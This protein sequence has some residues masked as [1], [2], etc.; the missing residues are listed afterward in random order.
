[1]QERPDKASLLDALTRFCA[2]E[3]QPAL[4]GDKALAFR[5]L[6]AA[7]LTSSMAEELRQEERLLSAELSRLA[8]LLPEVPLPAERRE[9]IRA[10]TA[11]LCERIRGGPALSSGP[12][13]DHVVQ[14]LR[15]QLQVQNPRFDLRQEIE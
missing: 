11:A 1:M 12:L 13:W 5:A 3:L 4:S 9:A 10:L 8:A 2:S 7:S 15:E 14:T 6:I